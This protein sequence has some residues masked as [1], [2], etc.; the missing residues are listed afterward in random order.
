[1]KFAE[2][3]LMSR[4]AGRAALDTMPSEVIDTIVK[5][6]VKGSTTTA[7]PT[8]LLTLRHI[9]GRLRAACLPY[10]YKDK[11]FTVHCPG[12]LSRLALDCFADPHFGAAINAL[13]ISGDHYD[14]QQWGGKAALNVLSNANRAALPNLSA[15]KVDSAALVA[16]RDAPKEITR[17]L[18]K[19]IKTLSLDY[20]STTHRGDV[21]LGAYPT[22]EYTPAQARD[23]FNWVQT[24][25]NV[26]SLTFVDAC[27]HYDFEG[28]AATMEMLGSCVTRLPALESLTLTTTWPARGNTLP[29][30][31]QT[32]W[33][34]SWHSKLRSLTLTRKIKLEHLAGFIHFACTT[35]TYLH[36]HDIEIAEGPGSRTM[37]LPNLLMFDWTEA[38]TVTGLQNLRMRN[39]RTLRLGSL[40]SNDRELLAC[41]DLRIFPLLEVIEIYN[42][43]DLLMENILRL[44]AACSNN[45][46]ALILRSTIE[47]DREE[48]RERRGLPPVVP[49]SLY[50]HPRLV[51]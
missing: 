12:Q 6:L 45:G 33:Q 27:E 29:A 43:A 44:K 51:F 26:K 19:S 46:L 39:L 48:K 42:L 21:V 5:I 24:C 4:D 9:S 11:M 49:R 40:V 20:R 2:Q 36:V 7:Q 18:A 50:W 13:M 31:S 14:S 47:A 28:C 30:H 38:T 37:T 34:T 25:A 23:V 3:A 17:F 15:L 22:P 10:L 1:M 41:I 16:I 8:D 35:L 32:T